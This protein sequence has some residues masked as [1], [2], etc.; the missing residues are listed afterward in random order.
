MALI[1]NA[2]F[3]V[4]LQA[5]LKRQQWC[6]PSRN[7]RNKN[8]QY[9]PGE[10][11]DKWPQREI[12][13]TSNSEWTFWILRLVGERTPRLSSVSLNTTS[14]SLTFIVPGE[15]CTAGARQAAPAV[16][17]LPVFLARSWYNSLTPFDPLTVLF[18]GLT[19]Q[20]PL[21]YVLFIIMN[22]PVAH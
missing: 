15:H 20:C 18:S 19:I 6:L 4:L 13:T 3:L 1:P 11:T 9:T 16:I 7:V 22:L 10:Q 17:F 5:A 12:M 14:L 21:F 2:N 8:Q